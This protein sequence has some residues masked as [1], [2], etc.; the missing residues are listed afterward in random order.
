MDDPKVT[1]IPA[2]KATAWGVDIPVLDGETIQ[3][4]IVRDSPQGTALFRTPKP[5]DK[6]WKVRL[7]LRIEETDK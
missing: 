4:V 5:G 7:Y 2:S 3:Q 1:D 6:D